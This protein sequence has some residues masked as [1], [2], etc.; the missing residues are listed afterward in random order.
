M[1]TTEPTE[2]KDFKRVKEKEDLVENRSVDQLF[3]IWSF[4]VHLY[5]TNS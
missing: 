3:L 1:V 4:V 2:T 5:A